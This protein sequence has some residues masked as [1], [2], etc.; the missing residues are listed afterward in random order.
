MGRAFLVIY[1]DAI[2]EKAIRWLT[3]A[4]KDTRVEFKSPK[5]P[6]PQNDKMWAALTDISDQ[7]THKG[8]KLKP[9]QWK[10]LFLDALDKEYDLVPSLDGSSFVNIGR[11]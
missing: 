5:R 7:L 10:M 1:N 8:R 3:K 4:P 2:R 9:D 11:R 6:L